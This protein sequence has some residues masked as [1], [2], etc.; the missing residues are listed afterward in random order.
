MA[1]IRPT[2]R[3]PFRELRRI[4]SGPL[5][6]QLLR[7]MMRTPRKMHA[8]PGNPST[9]RRLLRLLRVAQVV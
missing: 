9:T 4:I 6:A 7:K 2:V 3:C 8:R 1:R 5:Q